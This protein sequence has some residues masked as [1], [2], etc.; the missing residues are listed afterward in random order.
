MAVLEEKEN[1]GV[2]KSTLSDFYSRIVDTLELMIASET[3]PE[4]DIEQVRRPILVLGEPGIGKTMGIMSIINAFNEVLEGNMKLG[5]KKILLGQSIVGELS[6]IPVATHN[7]ETGEAT[8]IKV[9]SD[10]LPDEA[11]DGKYGILFLDEVTTADAAQ[12]LPA[13][14]LCDDTRNLGGYKLPEGW[15]VVLAGNGPDCANFKMLHDV[16]LNRVITIDVDFSYENDWKGW[17]QE[18]FIHDS[19]LAFLNF[20]PEWALKVES[21][22]YEDADIGKAFASP[23][24]WTSL[25]YSLKEIDRNNAVAQ[26][27]AE[28][29]ATPVAGIASKMRQKYKTKA[30]S[31]TATKQEQY[32]AIA[33][34]IV[35]AGAANAFN[36][37]NLLN[38]EL[39]F[40]PDKIMKGEEAVAMPA[41]ALKRQNLH[42]ILASCTSR[43]LKAITT[44]VD[45]GADVEDSTTF[46]NTVM[47]M[48]AN[49]L[50]WF[51]SSVVSGGVQRPFLVVYFQE[52]VKMPGVRKFLLDGRVM[53]RPTILEFLK[54][55]SRR[56]SSGDNV[57]SSTA[58]SGA[59]MKE[60]IHGKA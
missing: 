35:G 32:L 28:G 9:Q 36:A 27:K 19:I 21:N 39:K 18:N 60:A 2:I 25:S 11:R 3:Y 22:K 31:Q 23:R 59:A 38:K 56:K 49:S 14:A 58:V 17:A 16:V 13:L 51:Y 57:E 43:L 45:A 55:D 34:Q 52:M 24:S 20:S 10:S 12:V 54:D 29:Y 46:S 40:D 1:V 33:G 5:M 6:G 30:H 42:M 4:I 37:F 15:L 48:Y 53:S 7:S 50:E 44:E 26:G 41:D 8:L 47:A